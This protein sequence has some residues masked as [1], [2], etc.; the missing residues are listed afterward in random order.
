MNFKTFQKPKYHRTNTYKVL[1][2][3]NLRALIF[4]ASNGV[5]K[6]LSFELVRKGINVTLVS[7]KKY[8]LRKLINELKKV[9]FQ[10]LTNLNEYG[11][12]VIFQTG[13][14]KVMEQSYIALNKNKSLLD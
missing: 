9:S 5:G 11:F 12:K 1:M 6:M 8:K 3:K 13:L 14:P 4:G 10:P 2:K 7:R